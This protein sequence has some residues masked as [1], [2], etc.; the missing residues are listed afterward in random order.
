[1]KRRRFG[2]RRQA[3]ELEVEVDDLHFVP[4]R[5]S[6]RRRG[7]SLSRRLGWVIGVGIV[8]TYALGV[9]MNNASRQERSRASEAKPKVAVVQAASV[10]FDLERSLQKAEALA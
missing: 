1:M 9:D 6:E 5:Y 4:Q 3:E 8:I 10:A 2:C 7:K